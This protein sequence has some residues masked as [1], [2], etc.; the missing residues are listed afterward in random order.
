M[1]WERDELSHIAVALNETALLHPSSQQRLTA[2]PRNRFHD[3]AMRQA[4]M[5]IIHMKPFALILM[6]AAGAAASVPQFSVPGGVYTNDVTVRLSASPTSAVVRITLDGTEPTA[7]SAACSDA[8]TLTNST[9]VRARVFDQGAPAGPAVSQTYLLLD[10][11]VLSFSSNLPLLV[12]NTFG[13]SLSHQAPAP[14]SVRLIDPGPGGRSRL[15]SQAAFEGRATLKIRG[16]S[17]LQFPKHSFSFKTKDESGASLKASL[18]GLPADSDWILYAPYPDKTLMRDVLAYDLSRQMA[19]YAP[20]TRY[21]E[22]FATRSEHKLRRQTY[23]GVYVLE[24]RIKRGKERVNI[25]KLQSSDTNEPAISGGYIFKKD[26]EKGPGGFRTGHGQHFYYVDPKEQKLTRDQKS[27]LTGYLNRFERSL[28]GPD[29]KDPVRG[30]A[31]YIDPA[32]FIDLHWIVELSKNIDGYRLSNYLHKDREGKLKMEPIWDWNLSFGNANYS[33]G[34]M[35]EGWYWRL[36]SDGDYPWFGRLF[37]DPDFAQQ[38]ADR[39]WELRGKQFATTNLLGKIDALAAEL[40][41]APLR[42]FKRWRILGRGVWPNWYVGQTFADE[43][44]WMKQWIEERAAWIDRQFPAPPI[45][46]FDHAPN[47]PQPLVKLRAARGDIYYTLNG[48]DPR[49]PGGAVSPSAKLYGDPVPFPPGAKL[50]ARA[51][52]RKTWT[53]PCKAL[54]EP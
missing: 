35:P 38:Y 26:H 23:L 17:S 41:D 6:W 10:A 34:W 28:Y 14:V 49:A 31:A 52:S 37:A 21:V 5:P 20:R 7:A 36:V 22:V 44:D 25:A 50:C 32:S 18:L 51:F 15:T 43:V 54:N 19:H 16:T 9:L 11:D 4:L 24:E 29:F 12:I 13:Q 46:S 33:E 53:A 47:N 39:W 2:S 40:G 42:N 1:G 8:L 45:A 48:A 27:W 3:R 30:Y